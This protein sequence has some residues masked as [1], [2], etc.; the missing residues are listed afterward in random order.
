M[1]FVCVC[2]C[3]FVCVRVSVCIS[4]IEYV[5][6]SSTGFYVLTKNKW[7]WTRVLFKELKCSGSLKEVGG[8]SGV[9]PMWI[10]IKAGEEGCTRG[11]HGEHRG[12]RSIWLFGSMSLSFF[13][14]WHCAPPTS[15]TLD[16]LN[17]PEG[18]NK[19]RQGSVCCLHNT[20][21]G[22]KYSGTSSHQ[23]LV[24]SFSHHHP[25]IHPFIHLTASTPASVYGHDYHDDLSKWALS[26]ESH[27]HLMN[28]FH[29][30]PR[31]STITG[32]QHQAQSCTV[33]GNKVESWVY[34]SKLYSLSDLK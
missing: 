15:G 9:G 18:R 2:V 26:H 10:R 6:V 1:C 33:K 28:K 22:N 4:E 32:L 8:A 25:S 13:P 23:R 7:I 30:C 5:R 14:A 12:G 20:S 16:H 3:V 11:G 24:L 31:S 29:L 17:P 27:R 34:L 19:K 21:A